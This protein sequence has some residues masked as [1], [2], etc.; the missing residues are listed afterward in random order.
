[1]DRWTTTT[2]TRTDGCVFTIFHSHTRGKV[3]RKYANLV[4]KLVMTLLN[5]VA[6]SDNFIV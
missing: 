2:N 3:V 4:F 5:S 6:N 1:M